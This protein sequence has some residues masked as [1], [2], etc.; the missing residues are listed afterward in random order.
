M[1][2]ASAL[3]V[4]AFAAFV[5]STFGQV[6]HLN[7]NEQFTDGDRTSVTQDSNGT[8][9]SLSWANRRGGTS[10]G[11]QDGGIFVQST[12]SATGQIIA[13]QFTNNAATLSKGQQLNVSFDLAIT[14]LPTAFRFGVYDSNG[15]ANSVGTSGSPADGFVFHT[16]MSTTSTYFRY[17]QH[18]GTNNI[19]LISTVDTIL[20]Q[21]TAPGE[22]SFFSAVGTYNFAAS[23]IYSDDNTYDFSIKVTNLDD[24]SVL[25]GSWSQIFSEA[26]FATSF[27]T[28]ALMVDGTTGQAVFDNLQIGVSAAPIPEPSTYAAIFGG[29]ALLGVMARRRLSRKS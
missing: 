2:I 25:T 27:D 18:I 1:K 28:F 15:A 8:Y 7:V 17:E 13:A 5:G 19:N 23:I 10:I 24:N 4:A 11:M 9:T 14:Q 21:S 3:K 16:R 22:T 29:L 26:N 12:S 20:G 6:I